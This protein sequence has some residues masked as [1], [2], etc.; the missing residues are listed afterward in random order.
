MRIGQV[1]KNTNTSASTQTKAEN[2]NRSA[3]INKLLITIPIKIEKPIKPFLYSFF[4]G[5]KKVLNINGREKALKN[6]LFNDPKYLKSKKGA[7]IYQNM[8]MS[9]GSLNIT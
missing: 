3:V 7:L 9:T 2:S 5:L 6:D 1:K 8:T 4:H